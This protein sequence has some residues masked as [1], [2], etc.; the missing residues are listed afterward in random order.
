M[1][2]KEKIPTSNDKFIKRVFPH[3]TRTEGKGTNLRPFLLAANPKMETDAVFFLL[4][5]NFHFQDLP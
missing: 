1:P 4:R 5:G 2:G 3:A